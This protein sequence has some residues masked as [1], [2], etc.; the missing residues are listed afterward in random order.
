MKSIHKD[1][2][3]CFPK[4]DHAFSYGSGVFWQPGLY[5]RHVAGPMLDFVFGVNDPVS[6][7]KEVCSMY[8]R[9]V[10][11]YLLGSIRN[12]Y[13][14]RTLIGTLLITP[15]SLHLEQ[16]LYVVSSSSPT[17]FVFWAC[18]DIFCILLR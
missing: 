6:W 15:S 8:T 10:W 17:Y 1:I 5:S 4:I 16:T 2:V 7:H 13:V 3:R 9:I 11:S 14:R 12:N 18:A